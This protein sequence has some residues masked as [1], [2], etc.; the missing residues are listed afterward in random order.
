MLLGRDVR[1]ELNLISGVLCE[2]HQAMCVDV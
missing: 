1:R 2:L